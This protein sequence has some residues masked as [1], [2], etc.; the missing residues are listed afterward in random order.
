MLS[1]ISYKPD[2]NV[3]RKVNF[4]CDY[5]NLTVKNLGT[6]CI[7][8]FENPLS[9]V[10]KIIFQIENNPE[11]RLEY[12]NHH[13]SNYHLHENGFTAQFKNLKKL[14]P[15]IDEFNS[16][17][18]KEQNNW[19]N[20]N[21]KLI[22]TLKA[23]KHE[24]DKNMI[25]IAIKFL[26]NYMRC[27]HEL[28]FHKDDFIYLTRI[29]VSDFKFTKKSD[30]D[31]K[32]LIKSIMSK[33]I[34]TFPL[35]ESILNRKGDK[36]YIEIASNYI[37]NRTFTQQFEGILNFKKNPDIYGYYI[38]RI[39]KLTIPVNEVFHF[40]DVKLYNS[41]NE[42]FTHFKDLGKFINPKEKWTEFINKDDISVAIVKEN[43]SNEKS[44]SKNAKN[45][46]QYAL[47]YINNKLNTTCYID[48]YKYLT[49]IDF[50]DL[51]FSASFDK[52]LEPLGEHDLEEIE[53]DNAYKQ[54]EDIN[55]NAK[56]K[57]VYAE[58]FFQR[59]LISQELSDYW[60]YLECLIPLKVDENGKYNKQIKSRSAEILLLDYRYEFINQ[61]TS[62]ILNL[63][64]GH[65]NARTKDSL[66]YDEINEIFQNWKSSNIIKKTSSFKTH[67]II[68]EFHEL[69]STRNDKLILKKHYDYFFSI[70]HEL[71]EVRNA[72]IHGG[73]KN[74]YADTKL[75][76]IVPRYVQIIRNAIFSEVKRNKYKKMDSIID[77]LSSRYNNYNS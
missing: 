2:A 39:F 59:A 11:R 72:Y 15:I 76:L 48:I 74:E 5:F 20:N 3:E 58:K 8:D 62:E 24:L 25:R 37:D 26:T 66:A 7:W 73:V 36:N 45:T 60:H 28:N 44:G 75:N 47:N 14:W 41:R 33:N 6:Y 55:S 42:K 16:V 43:I 19:L 22:K 31:I 27:T 50:T 40:Q 53:G 17:P 1:L 10:D 51:G 71:Y 63:L 13:F 54:L 65:A 64:N 52:S 35:P 61:I 9:V 21:S 46:I 23:L 77:H 29:I 68:N 18:K 12:L 56:E 57:F 69:Y 67:P 49:T 34:N 4:F 38:F 32:R 70:M 30:Q